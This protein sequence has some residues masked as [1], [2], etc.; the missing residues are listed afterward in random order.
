MLYRQIDARCR[1]ASTRP[2]RVPLSAGCSKSA[3]ALT[4]RPLWVLEF[5]LQSAQKREPTSGLEPLACSLRVISHA[6]QRLARVCESRISNRFALLRLARRCTVLRS[7]WCQSGVRSP[8]ITRRRLLK[9]RSSAS[10]C[11]TTRYRNRPR[12]PNG[13]K[14]LH[15]AS[16]QA[17][18]TG[19][20]KG[21]SQNTSSS[22]DYSRSW[23][24]L[25]NK[26]NSILGLWSR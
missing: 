4:P 18:Y 22:P 26:G 2:R 5:S 14:S 17:G 3:P 24:S 21:T 1:H 25:M 16:L 23:I 9:S 19:S 8:W 15:R 7:R 6:L 12:Y 11:T 13:N 10:L 20:W